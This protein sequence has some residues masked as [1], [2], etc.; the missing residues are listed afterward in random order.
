MLRRLK[1]VEGIGD[2]C[3]IL[4]WTRACDLLVTTDQFIEDVHFLRDVHKPE[5][6][7]WKAAARGLSDIAAMGGAAQYCFVS[8]ALGEWADKAWLRRLYSGLTRLTRQYGV[9]VA[10]GD[11]S[12]AARTYCDIVILGYCARG[13]A[14]RRQGARAGHSIYVTG[15]LGGAQLGL[16]TRSG[17]AW[18]KHLRP[19]PRLRVGQA[20]V[21]KASA[22]MDLSDGLSLDLRRLCIESGV[23]A[24]LNDNVPVFPGA[25]TEHALHGGDDYELLFTAP[26]KVKIPARIA[27]IKVTRIGQIIQGPP[28]EVRVQG[29]VLK[30]LGWDSWRAR[31][32]SNPRPAGSKPDALSN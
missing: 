11:L 3:A 13:K 26:S 5:D 23:A 27:G 18:R 14:L 2:D 29:L 16:E 17:S 9:V 31:R 1:G 25:S 8:L 24:R 22:A 7:G 12:Q 21:G 4:P 10:G 15:R 19:E 28:G 6:C 32:D 20:L 30:P